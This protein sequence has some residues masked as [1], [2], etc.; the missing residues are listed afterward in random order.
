M[1]WRNWK[2]G[3]LVSLVLSVFVAGA[4]LTA[5]MSWRQFLAVFCS[6]ALT[7]FGAFIYQNPPEKIS[8]DTTQTT[9]TDK[10]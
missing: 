10:L 5:G 8:F 1:K 2:I 7:H 9:K 4:G 6:A 3:A